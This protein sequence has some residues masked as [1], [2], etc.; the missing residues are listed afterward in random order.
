MS[1]TAICKPFTHAAICLALGVIACGDVENPRHDNENEVITTVVLTFTPSGGGTPVVATFNDPDGDGGDA[2]SVEAIA[3]DPSTTYATTVTFLNA[4][5]DPAEDITEEIA[6]EPE[7]H[8]VFFTGSAVR[9]P[10]TGD[11]PAAVLEHAYD[12]ADANGDPI[13]L[14]NTVHT[15]ASGTGELTLT[16]R[17]L[18]AVNGTPVKTAELAA[19]VASDGIGA[20]PGDSDAQVTFA[21]A[22]P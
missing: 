6:A 4:L 3:L 10:A 17:H 21:V 12:D 18:P 8:Q 22:V 13:G 16:L 14:T 19:T 11:N 9:G 5:E 1:H 2:P 20:L 15:I 7:E